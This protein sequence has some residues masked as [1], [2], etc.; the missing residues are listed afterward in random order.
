MAVPVARLFEAF[1]DTTI[2][3]R[4]LPGAVMRERTS[5]PG[6]SARFDWDDGV[7][8]VNVTFGALGDDK[9][10]V[11]VEHDHLPDAQAAAEPKVFWRERLGA[12]KTLLE[13]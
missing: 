11:A 9:S 4:W 12:L 7:S 3:E 13:G 10:Q 1:G 6:R 5:Q 8:R 2:R